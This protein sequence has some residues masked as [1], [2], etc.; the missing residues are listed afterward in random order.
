M[1]NAAVFDMDD[2][3]YEPLDPFRR[4]FHLSFPSAAGNIPIEDLYAASRRHSEKSFV[5]LEAGEITFLE[6]NI[7]RITKACA[8]FGLTISR[9]EALIFQEYYEEEQEKIY[10][11][12]EMIHV[13]EKL[14]EKGICLGVLSNGP[15]EH[16]WKKVN[17]LGLTRWIPEE[18]IF[19]SEGIGFSK[20]DEQAFLYVAGKM[21]LDRNRT[22]F[23]GDSYENDIVGAK[24]AGWKAIWMNHRRKKA[25]DTEVVPDETVFSPKELLGSEILFS[26]N[27]QGVPSGKKH[28]KNKGN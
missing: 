5:R 15:F 1:I 2:T 26:N 23:I 6:H 24:R 21:G 17:R 11:F 18:N 12:P 27:R 13:F 4:A 19:V 28:F 3:L 16:Q 14:Q 20:P 10:L 9:D 22:V 25:P 8:D 7:Y